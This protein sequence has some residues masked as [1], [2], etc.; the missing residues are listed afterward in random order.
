[1]GSSSSKTLSDSELVT[2]ALKAGLKVY[3]GFKATERRLVFVYADS[4]RSSPKLFTILPTGAIE[5]PPDGK[6]LPPAKARGLITFPF[7]QSLDAAKAQPHLKSHCVW[8]DGDNHA[9]VQLWTVNYN[10]DFHKVFEESF[11]NPDQEHFKQEAVD[12]LYKAVAGL[13]GEEAR[14]QK[15]KYCTKATQNI[16]RTYVGNSEQFNKFFNT[17]GVKE[18]LGIQK[19]TDEEIQVGTVDKKGYKG[20]QTFPYGKQAGI[21]QVLYKRNGYT[22]FMCFKELAQFATDCRL[23]GQ[24]MP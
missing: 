17:P 11:E 6:S 20:N 22:S 5:G 14:E 3:A 4:F 12:N 2:L 15:V 13:F 19:V 7:A 21:E 23:H 10:D 24:I 16:D 8:P 18:S 1:M 9:L